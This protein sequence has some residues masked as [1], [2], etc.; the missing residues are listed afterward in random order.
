LNAKLSWK[1]WK[2]REFLKRLIGRGKL[3]TLQSLAEAVDAVRF[4]VHRPGSLCEQAG[5]PAKVVSKKCI[6]RGEDFKNIRKE[7]FRI[8]V[9][10]MVSVTH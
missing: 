3:N 1:L 7:G 4:R 8:E 9:S 5:K 6:F 2:E 10:T